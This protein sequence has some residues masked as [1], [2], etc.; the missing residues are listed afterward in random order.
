MYKIENG[1][2]F[3]HMLKKMYIYMTVPEPR[4]SEFAPNQS[5]SNLNK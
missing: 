5:V 4:L 3:D 2:L 1:N